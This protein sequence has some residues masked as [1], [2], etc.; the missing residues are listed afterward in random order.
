MNS[1][2]ILGSCPAAH[3]HLGMSRWPAW[4][5]HG[6]GCPCFDGK[7]SGTDAKAGTRAHARLAWILNGRQGEAPEAEYAEIDAAEWAAGEVEKHKANSLFT[8]MPHVEL[9][10]ETYRPRSVTDGIFGTPDVFWVDR[11]HVHVFDFKLYGDGSKDY[12]AQLAGY[13][14]AIISD[15]IVE[16]GENWPVTLHTLNGL[17]RTVQTVETTADECDALADRIISDRLDPDR[18]PRACDWCGLCAHAAR[19]PELL[20][21]AATVS[22]LE[23]VEKG[24]DISKLEITIEQK[25]GGLSHLTLAGLLAITKPLKKWIEDVEEK[26]KR[27]AEKSF[28]VDE[29]GKTITGFIEGNGVRFE[30]RQRRGQRKID[31][32]CGLAGAVKDVLPPSSFIKLCKVSHADVVAALQKAGMPKQGA[33]LT[34]EPYFPR[35]EGGYSLERV[36]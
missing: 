19:C 32:I 30:L 7:P 31:D 35:G 10:I 6:Q 3:H 34:I 26:A 18:E 17:S 25:G 29:S 21:I 36:V 15:D 13:A 22:N 28:S 16:P 20:H 23:K 27:E 9:Q 2:E 14:S 11:K 24:V 33:E 1:Q 8:V 5:K 12:T 4:D